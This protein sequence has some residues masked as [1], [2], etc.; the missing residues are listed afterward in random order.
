I[1]VIVNKSASPRDI[2]VINSNSRGE[3]Y[4]AERAV[5]IVV[6]EV[7]GVIGK[8]G[9]KNIEPAVAVII[10]DANSHARLLVPIFAV[11]AA[12]HH[13]HIS[14]R[15]VMIVAKQNAGLGV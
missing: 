11:G 14:E 5:P 15:A 2:L 12:G 1:V 7:A 8:I 9:F 6:I 4:I 10:A 13:R 3:C